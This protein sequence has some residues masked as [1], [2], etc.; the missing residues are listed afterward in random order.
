MENQNMDSL[1]RL[2]AAIEELVTVVQNQKERFNQEL[3]AKNNRISGLQTEVQNLNNA[4]N[5]RKNQLE[6]LD[7]KNKLLAA[8]L[9]ESQAKLE[10]SAGNTEE[11]NRLRNMLDEANKTIAEWAEKYRTAEEKLQQNQQAIDETS[12]QINSVIARLEKV[13]QENGTSNDNN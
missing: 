7:N 11:T 3:T 8:Q 9:S 13:L 6:E 4:L 12:Q 1:K 2:N 10:S 5:N